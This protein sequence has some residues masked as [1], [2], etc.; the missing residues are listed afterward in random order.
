MQRRLSHRGEHHRS[1]RGAHPA[2]IGQARRATSATGA[3]LAEGTDTMRWAPHG[4]P[5]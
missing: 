5:W 3:K 2:V 1:V 4:Q